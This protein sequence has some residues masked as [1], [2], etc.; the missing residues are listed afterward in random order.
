[1]K[2]ARF[3][4]DKR[5]WTSFSFILFIVSLWMPWAP[6][7]YEGYRLVSPVRFVSILLSLPRLEPPPDIP[8]DFV[9]YYLQFALVICVCAIVATLIGW[10]LQCAVVIVR[11]TCFAKRAKP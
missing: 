2:V 4:I 11:T 8:I 5:W 7:S 9:G 10:V 6:I 1:M 3:Q